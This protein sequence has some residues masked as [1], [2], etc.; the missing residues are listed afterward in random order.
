[1]WRLQTVLEEIKLDNLDSKYVFAKVTVDV[2]ILKVGEPEI[3]SMG[4]EK[5]DVV[6]ADHSKTAKIALWEEQVGSLLEHASYRCE[7]VA[8]GEWSRTKYQ[9]ILNSS[10]S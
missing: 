2:R 1:M 7:N 6:I 10:M 4:K 9:R 8:V 3:V 5:Q